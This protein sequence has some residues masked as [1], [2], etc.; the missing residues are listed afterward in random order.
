TGTSGFSHQFDFVIPKSGKHPE[1]V[2]QAVNNPTRQEAETLL[3][4]WNDTR[5]ARPDE[6]RLYAVL[7]DESAG[8][9]GRITVPQLPPD[10][11]AAFDRYQVTPFPWSR[12]RQ[13]ATELAA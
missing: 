9:E 6:S 12:R 3:F 2:L 8:D 13:Y 11:A 4:A 7:N 10:I 1:R 5:Q